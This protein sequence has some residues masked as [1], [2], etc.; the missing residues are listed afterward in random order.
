M[1]QIKVLAPLTLRRGAGNSLAAAAP[2]STDGI[3]TY[4]SPSPSLP[5]RVVGEVDRELII[6]C[7]NRYR[8]VDAEDEGEAN[9]NGHAQFVVGAGRRR[10]SPAA[11]A[12]GECRRCAHQPP[13]SSA[14]PQQLRQPHR[15]LQRAQG[16][17]PH[18]VGLCRYIPSIFMINIK[19]CIYKRVEM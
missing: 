7:N 8:G 4:P 15:R 13:R 1:G 14:G 5:H 2:L 16:R 18:P 11:S 9:A 3:G 12:L 10:V 17:H 6:D 19:I